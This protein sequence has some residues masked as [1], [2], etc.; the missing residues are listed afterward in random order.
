MEINNRLILRI[1]VI[2]LLSGFI[3]EE[4]IL[5]D[6]SFHKKQKVKG[7]NLEVEI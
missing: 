1:L 7:N 4:K 5:M 2:K 3:G 6:K